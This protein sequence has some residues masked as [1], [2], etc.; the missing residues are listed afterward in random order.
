MK[1]KQSIYKVPRKKKKA[2]K[3]DGVSWLMY[4]TKIAILPML[5]Y[6]NRRYLLTFLTNE[7]YEYKENKH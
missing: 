7:N 5:N 2:M 1:T 3:R 4:K 6:E